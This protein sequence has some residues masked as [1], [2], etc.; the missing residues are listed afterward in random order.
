MCGADGLPHRHHK[1]ENRLMAE[2]SVWDGTP[3]PSA[4][5]ACGGLCPLCGDFISVPVGCTRVADAPDT[6][7]PG[8]NFHN[9][10]L[11]WMLHQQGREAYNRWRDA[12]PPGSYVS[13]DDLMTEL[14]KVEAELGANK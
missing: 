2:F 10:E 13:W 6:F 5:L 8:T 1:V 4:D 11:G 9:C 12:Q 14:E 7:I 3:L